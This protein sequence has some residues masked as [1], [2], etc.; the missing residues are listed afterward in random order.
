[1]ILVSRRLFTLFAALA[2][3]AVLALG[4]SGYLFF[5]PQHS[6]PALEAKLTG[7][8]FLFGAIFTALVLSVLTAHIIRTAPRI[9]RELDRILQSGSNLSLTA[10]LRA[11]RLGPISRT[12]LRL[13]SRIAELNEKQSLKMSAQHNLIT[14]LTDNIQAPLLITDISGRILYVSRA[15]EKS[16]NISHNALL[17]TSVES[18]APNILMQSILGDLATHTSFRRERK[19]DLPFTVFPVYNRLRQADYCIFDF[20]E[21]SPLISGTSREAESRSSGNARQDSDSATSSGFGSSHRH[22]LL[23]GMLG[24]SGKGSTGL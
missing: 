23:G 11:R 24:R 14:F 1:M 4:V 3:L 10:Q 22:G 7:E 19:G 13:Y 2:L 5:H 9:N 15:L 21:N 8:W 12:L 18:F 20:R 17:G 16:Y 6:L